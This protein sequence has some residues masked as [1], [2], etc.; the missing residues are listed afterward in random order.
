MLNQYETAIQGQKEQPSNRF[1]RSL[2]TLP[3]VQ[4]PNDPD[5]WEGVQRRAVR[6]EAVQFVLETPLP[7]VVK[8]RDP[9]WFLFAINAI[10]ST[11]AYLSFL[12]DDAQFQAFLIDVSAA[13]NVP[14][15]AALT[16]GEIC[17]I[18]AEAAQDCEGDEQ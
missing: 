17:D 16:Y 10:E 13:L 5:Y 12:D 15:I 7:Q 1:A 18:R 6:R 2:V 9:E 14:S 3:P 8:R 4:N 11:A